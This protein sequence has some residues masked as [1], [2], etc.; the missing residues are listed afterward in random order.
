MAKKDYH[1][2]LGDSKQQYRKYQK[3]FL[4]KTYEAFTVRFKKKEDADVIAALKKLYNKTAYIS[5]LVRADISGE[6]RIDSY[7][8][9]QPEDTG[10]KARVWVVDRPA[11]T[12]TINHE[13]VGHWE[14]VPLPA[15]EKT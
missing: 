3:D 6:R 9:V 10:T 14:D 7:P 8:Q 12:E 1:K 4:A 2:W 13:E 11:Y 15:D 5:D